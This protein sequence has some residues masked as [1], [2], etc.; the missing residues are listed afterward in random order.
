[1]ADPIRLELE[2]PVA[3]IV[4]DRPPL[5]I[6]TTAMLSDLDRA[7][8][9]ASASGGVRLIRLE[10]RGKLFS[11]GVDV[12]DHVGERLA[13]MMEALRAVFE[14]IEGIPQPTVSLVHGA[15]LGG[16]CELAL[17]T[18]LCLASERASFG[19]PEVRLGVFAPPASVLLPRIAGERRALSLLLS[20]ETIPARE[21][22]R[23]GIVN[24]VF[25]DD[26][27]PA[28]AEAWLSRLLELSGAALRFAKRA[29]VASRGLPVREAY[30]LVHRIYLEE[31]MTTRDAQE[32]LEAFLEKRPPRWIH[33]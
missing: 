27:F 19:Q 22:E 11:A 10:A 17:A 18:D 3:R 30:G 16:G 24:R 8:R 28:D 13:A 7:F 29:V 31:L 12:A 2:G 21:A 9:E 5:N 33:E 1:V 26:S 32:G 15:A 23:Y 6:L 4:L 20:G 14:T 25:P